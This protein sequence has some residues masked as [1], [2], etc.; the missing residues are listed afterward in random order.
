[1]FKLLRASLQAKLIIVFMLILLIPTGIITYY[2]TD[3]ISRTVT[4]GAQSEKLRNAETQAAEIE[5]RLEDIER[6]LLFLSR[7]P[8]MRR[9]A[10]APDQSLE[11][12]T[13]FMQS[14]LENGNYREVRLLAADGQEALHL[15]KQD[16][17]VT[18]VG[19][20][21]LTNLGGEAYFVEASNLSTGQVYIS[22]VDLY[23]VDG[24][25]SQPYV[26]VIDYA[27]PV[28]GNNG[29]FAGVIAI[30]LDARAIL[31]AAAPSGPGETVA[32]VKTDG[33]YLLNTADESKL[34]SHI[35]RNNNT[36]YRDK[37]NDAGPMLAQQRSE[38]ILFG[39]ADRP[40]LMQTFIRV[41]PVGQENIQ[42]VIIYEYPIESILQEVVNARAVVFL[43]TIGALAAAV[44]IA[45]FITRAITRPVQRLSQVADAVRKGQWDAQVPLVRTGDE[46][47]QLATAFD[48]MLKEVKTSYDTLEHRVVERTAQLAE[49]QG[50]A[51]K[52]SQAK[53]VF[54]SNMSH[55]LRTPLNVIIGYTSSMRDMPMMYDN[56]PLPEV[57]RKDVDLIMTNGQYLL[58][59]INDILDL[60]KIEAGRLELQRSSTDLLDIFKGVI[61]TSIGLVRDKPVQ[62]RPDFPET[63]PRVNADPVRIRQVILNLMSNAIKFTQTGSVTLQARLEGDAVRIAIVDT[64]IGI[65]EKALAHIFDRYRQAEANTDRHYG[66]T[67]LGLD[68]SKQLCVMHGTDL[69]VSSVVGKGST[70]SFTLPIMTGEETLPTKPADTDLNKLVQFFDDGEPT[71][72]LNQTILLVMDNTALSH[73]LRGALEREGHL[74]LETDDG[75]MAYEMAVSVLPDVILLDIEQNSVNGWNILDVLKADPQTLNIPVILCG[76][77]DDAARRQK[78]GSVSYLQKPFT[79]EAAIEALQA[80]INSTQTPVVP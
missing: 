8:A 49:A 4:E 13:R 71:S 59:L 40:D 28:Y 77:Q 64:G 31:S 2:T 23:R 19:S 48:K 22:D 37:P 52:A 44:V 56:E 55:E 74:A 41:T 69:D 80:V 33:S 60:S 26:P 7:A 9:Y 76:A 61:A 47:E 51:E 73:Y 75:T 78:L 5:R 18:V 70:F 11:G 72:V 39:S 67:G 50:R 1:M 29:A 65:P 20:E 6:N 35:L 17:V 34:Y 45:I 12:L 21:R 53:S 25:I 58:G 42:W 68:I 38:G 15:V 30:R 27:T 10:S 32:I 79:S 36:L 3:S 16:G 63:L 66:G 14:F 62:I 43:I 54:L 46:I 57:Y 24:A